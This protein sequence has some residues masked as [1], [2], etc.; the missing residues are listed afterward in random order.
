MQS[1]LSLLPIKIKIKPIKILDIYN[2]EWKAK[3]PGYSCY[4]TCLILLGYIKISLG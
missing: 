4:E 3:Q 2:S 1:T